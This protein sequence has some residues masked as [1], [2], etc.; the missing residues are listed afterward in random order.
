MVISFTYFSYIK[1]GRYYNNLATRVI[2]NF[3]G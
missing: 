2:S 1:Q 3:I